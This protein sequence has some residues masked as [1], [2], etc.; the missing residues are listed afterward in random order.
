MIW[1]KFVWASAW[2]SIHERLAT[3]HLRLSVRHRERA[4]VHNERA[5]DLDWR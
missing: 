4:R 3:R 1:L 2:F 5:F